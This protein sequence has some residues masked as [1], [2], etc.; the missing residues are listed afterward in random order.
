MD[1]KRMLATK[2]CLSRVFNRNMFREQFFSAKLAFFERTGKQATR[3]RLATILYGQ[4]LMSAFGSDALNNKM[5]LIMITPSN[6]VWHL[7][8][9]KVPHLNIR[10]PFFYLSVCVLF[11]WLTVR[12]EEKKLYFFLWFRLTYRIPFWLK[13]FEQNGIDFHSLHT[14]G[15]NHKKIL[16]I[17]NGWLMLRNGKNILIKMNKRNVENF[18]TWNTR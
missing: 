18:S 4:I 15:L 10:Q 12:E 7:C 8:D 13:F 6:R 5:N 9:K 2:M 3:H 1:G 11:F 16:H 14:D 17:L